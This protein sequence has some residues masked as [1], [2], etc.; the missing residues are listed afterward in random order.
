MISK[1]ELKYIQSLYHKK[2]RDKES[3]F[4]VEGPK[5]VE[6]L[7]HSDFKVL[8]VWAVPGPWLQ[9]HFN[10]LDSVPFQEITTAQLHKASH[11]ETPNQVIAIAQKNS[12][13]KRTTD[14]NSPKNAEPLLTLVLDGIQDPGNF[15]TLVRVADWFGVEQII[16]SPDSVDLYNPKV[17]QSTMGSIFRTAVH[18]CNL[19]TYLEK[20]LLPVYGALLNGKNL[21]QEKLENSG[22]ILVIGNESKGIRPEILPF[23]SQ[24]VTIPSF[25][26]AESL[27][28]A[29]AGAII[30][31]HLRLPS[32]N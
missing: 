16:A 17:I 22:G 32:G 3:A 11:F 18:Y 23:I 10:Q 8:G 2:A 27:N 26:Q 15:G 6:E 12:L 30:L 21:G 25:G 1:N 13:Q 4:I 7:L 5:M 20:Q 19:A 29:V 28:A 14:Q 9:M 24:A 31:S